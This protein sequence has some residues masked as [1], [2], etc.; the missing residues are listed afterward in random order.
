MI[1]LIRLTDRILYSAPDHET[2]QPILAAILGDRYTLMMDGGVSPEVARAFTSALRMQTG[3]RVDF[4]VVTHWHWDHT[5][6]LAGVDAPVI[7]HRNT[8]AHLKRMA[9]YAS[10]EDDALEARIADGEEITFCADCIRKVYPGERRSR[11]E[12]RQ[13][14]IVYD[15]TLTLDLGGVRCNLIPLPP[16]HTN[17]SVALHLAQEGVLFLGDST[18]PNSYDRPKYYSVPAVLELADLVR[19]LGADCIVESHGEPM[20]EETFW[21]YNGILEIAAHCV[22]AGITD[23]K[24]L[25]RELKNSLGELPE[26]AEEIAECFIN[27]I[28]R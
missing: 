1:E 14:D 19:S 24:S 22:K 27:G 15:C 26:D 4:V 17:D 28:G 21:A 12:I 9:G 20:N 23:E 5:F 25:L 11:I 7:A 18:G 10:W 16:V 6:G 13:A 3:R 8:A 2:D